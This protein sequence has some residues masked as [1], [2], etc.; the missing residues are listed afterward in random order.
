MLP[1]PRRFSLPCFTAN[2]SRVRLLFRPALMT[3]PREMKRSPHSGD[4]QYGRWQRG[5]RPEK[6]TGRKAIQPLSTELV[7][8]RGAACSNPP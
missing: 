7:A 6:L 1:R 3:R 5:R 2:R 4:E 8:R